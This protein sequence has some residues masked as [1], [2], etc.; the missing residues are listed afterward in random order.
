MASLTDEEALH[1]AQLHQQLEGASK[2]QVRH[3]RRVI[4]NRIFRIRQ[5]REEFD[6]GLRK[7]IEQQL[8]PDQRLDTFTF[9]WDIAPNEPLRVISPYDWTAAGGLFEEISVLCDDGI[10]RKE[11]LCDPAAFTK[12]K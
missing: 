12:Q 9:N 4:R 8:S 3:M 11:R 10:M 6:Q 1:I 2:K 5:G 7:F